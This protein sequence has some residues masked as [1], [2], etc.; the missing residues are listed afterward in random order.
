MSV[1]SRS[2]TYADLLS[3]RETRDERMEL[4]E[5]EIVVTP[6]PIPMHA[7]VAHRLTVLL[8][9]AIVEPGLGLV[10]EAPLDVFLD[11]R[12]VLQPDLL[13]LLQDRIDL[14][15]ATMIESAPSLA[16][17]IISPST[18][19]RDRGIKRELYARYGVPEYWIV[20]AHAALVT[21]F[22][23]LQDGRYRSE[24]AVR[25]SAVSATIPGLSVDLATL[26]APVPGAR[27]LGMDAETE[28]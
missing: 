2:S 22:S 17:E 11:D 5:G 12:N 6:S 16:I 19:P 20:D 4:I 8:D 14:F 13:V 10:L 27:F 15:G 28:D 1:T 21:I 24:Q 23:D 26:F 3:E 18:A 25:D 7:L 9:R